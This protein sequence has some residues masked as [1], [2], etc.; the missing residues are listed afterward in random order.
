MPFATLDQANGGAMQTGTVGY[1]SITQPQ[2]L[3]AVGKGS[4]QFVF[5]GYGCGRAMGHAQ[6]CVLA[7]FSI[8]DYSLCMSEDLH[9]YDTDKSALG[10]IVVCS[11][12]AG[13]MGLLI[14]WIIWA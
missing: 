14:G 3:A 5:A 6:Y 11:L 8:R 9:H 7:I 12:C 1:V 4:Y 13:L 2:Q 10:G